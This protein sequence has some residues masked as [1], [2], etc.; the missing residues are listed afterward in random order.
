MG[1]ATTGGLIHFASTAGVNTGINVHDNV[2]IF[3]GATGEGI[4]IDLSSGATLGVVARN[5]LGCNI[6]A[7]SVWF[8]SSTEAVFGGMM[9]FENY[10]TNLEAESAYLWGNL[11]TTAST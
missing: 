9:F 6:D 11:F 1:Q 5:Y 3:G 8:G 2:V 7:H 4:C 10:C